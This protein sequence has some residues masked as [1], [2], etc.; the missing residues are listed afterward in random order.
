VTVIVT[1]PG[2]NVTPAVNAET[3]DG[4]QTA[5]PVEP[6]AP[7]V[8]VDA[9]AEPAEQVAPDAAAPAATPAEQQPQQ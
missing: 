2:S 4:D 9:S 7:D 6:T 3:P 5:A 1:V 8:P